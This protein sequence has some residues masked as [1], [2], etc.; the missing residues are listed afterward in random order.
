MDISSYFVELLEEKDQ[1]V[2]PGLG[3]FFKKRSA[4]YYDETANI[5]YPPSNRITFTEEYMH[6][7]KLV[8]FINQKSKSSLT[9]I[10]AIL[11]EYVRELKNKLKTEHK[12]TLGGIG[13]LKS[14]NGR[15][16]LDTPQQTPVDKA[17]FGLPPAISAPVM[18]E[19]EEIQL[20][21]YSLAQQALDTA[22]SDDEVDVQPR[23]NTYKIVLLLLVIAILASFVGIY[24]INPDFYQKVVNSW[25]KDDH[26]SQT[27]LPV[28][29]APDAQA[30]Q[31]ADSVYKN[32][33]LESRLKSDFSDVEKVKDSADVSVN[34]QILPKNTG[35]RYEI[36]IGGYLKKNQALARVQQLKANG[37]NAY[38]VEDADGPLVKISCAVFY[39][40]AEAKKELKKVQQDLNPEAFIKPIKTLK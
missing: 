3:R 13:E 37:I 23:G 14:E 22:M 2:I 25:R 39:S 33:D 5:F 6:D 11:D 28:N 36:I 16:I 34:D 24:F 35:I 21:E 4:G 38:I 18:H 7:D 29:P 40:E 19:P 17:F 31:N 12:V 32:M 30:I 15:Y 9:S 10:Y 1:V 20:E 27:P 8:H 26:T